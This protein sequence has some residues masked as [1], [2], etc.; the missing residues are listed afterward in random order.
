M[1]RTSIFSLAATLLLVAPSPAQNT[2][3]RET[4]RVDTL[5]IAQIVKREGPAVVMIEVQD[6]GGKPTGQ[7]SGVIIRGDGII[8]TNFHVLEGACEL[9]VSL[10]SQLPPLRKR[11]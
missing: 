7:A 9:R 8:A 10:P 2:P 3:A 6:D 1:K 5:S 4:R 11:D